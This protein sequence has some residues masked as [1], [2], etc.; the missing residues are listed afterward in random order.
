MKK[1]YLISMICFIAWNIGTTI[2]AADVDYDKIDMTGKITEGSIIDYAMPEG[3]FLLIIKDQAGKHHLGCEFP[4]VCVELMN[5]DSEQ[6]AK[7]VLKKY[8]GKKARFT[9][10]QSQFLKEINW[11]NNIID[12]IEFI[13]N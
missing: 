6:K 4:L 1:I 12:K 13:G 3:T 8:K 2:F 5:A 9:F 7:D 10:G 11:Y